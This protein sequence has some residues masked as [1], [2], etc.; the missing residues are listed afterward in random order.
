MTQAEESAVLMRERI[1]QLVDAKAD[2][3]DGQVYAPVLRQLSAE[4]RLLTIPKP[5]KG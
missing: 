4:I 2:K 5:E 1:A 3:W